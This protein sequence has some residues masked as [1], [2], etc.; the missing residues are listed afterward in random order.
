MSHFSLLPSLVSTKA[1]LR[2]P[3]R[4]RTAVIGPPAANVSER[5]AARSRARSPTGRGAGF[6][7]TD[8]RPAGAAVSAMPHGRLYSLPPAIAVPG[9]AVRVNGVWI[10]TRVT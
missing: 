3:T 7:Y 5:P 2:V 10:G 1:P 4:T 6:S 8:H 9:V